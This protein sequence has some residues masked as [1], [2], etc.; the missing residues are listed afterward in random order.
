MLK[1]SRNSPTVHFN[2]TCLLWPL[3]SLSVMVLVLHLFF[4]SHSSVIQS[5][6]QTESPLV[7][8]SVSLKVI[9]LK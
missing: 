4:V 5:V 9:Q 6:S 7:Y 2:E 8:M 1:Q 3:P